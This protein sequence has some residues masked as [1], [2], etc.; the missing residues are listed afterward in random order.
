MGT[1]GMVEREKVCETMGAATLG[2]ALLNTSVLLIMSNLK[3]P[4]T[5]S[6]IPKKDLPLHPSAQSMWTPLKLLGK[7]FA[8]VPSSVLNVPYLVSIQEYVSYSHRW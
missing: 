2:T 3:A 5:R 8:K 6:S 4:K 7:A 1:L